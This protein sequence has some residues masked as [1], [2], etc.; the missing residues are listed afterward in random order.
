MNNPKVKIKKIGFSR[1]L[2]IKRYIKDWYTGF[3]LKFYP[4]F[5]YKFSDGIIK[6]GVDELLIKR[7]PK[8]PKMKKVDGKW[9]KD[10]DDDG[11][12]CYF[13]ARY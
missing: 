4:P 5:R 11:Y 1:Y 12:D 2:L 3:M 7:D 13:V 6:D 9:V 10:E 8:E